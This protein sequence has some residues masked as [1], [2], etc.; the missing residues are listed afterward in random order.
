M[1]EQAA[2][3]RQP[4]GPGTQGNPANGS[5]QGRANNWF[6]EY[7]N[8][9]PIAIFTCAAIFTYLLL[10]YVGRIGPLDAL[11]LYLALLA[12]GIPLLIGLVR[13]L[14]KLEYCSRLAAYLRISVFVARALQ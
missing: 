4:T 1:S 6:S 12:G 9:A 10:R 8:D 5:K 14:F 3:L 13:Q 7:G 11:P 2:L